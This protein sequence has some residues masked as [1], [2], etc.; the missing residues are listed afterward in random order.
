MASE[1]ALGP[2]L[3]HILEEL[4][5][6]I[7]FTGAAIG[8]LE[9]DEVVILD[10]TGPAPCDRVIGARICLEQDSGYRRVIEKQAPIVVADIWEDVGLPGSAWPI[11]DEMLSE[12]MGYARSWL[13]AP[14]VAKGK[15]IGV[16]RLDHVEPGRFTEAEGQQVLALAYQVAV[17]IV[18]AQLHEEAQRTAAM[19]ERERIARELHDSVSQALYGIV[20]GVHATRQRLGPEQEWIQARLDYLLSLAET[21]LAEMRALIFELRPDMKAVGG[22]VGALERHADM[23]RARYGLNVETDFPAEPELPSP[24]KEALYRIAQEGTNNIGKHADAR[25]VRMRLQQP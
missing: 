11:W 8:L 9:K 20:L 10:Y 13:G 19:A 4:K 15:T 14:L 25:N 23:L 12:A 2:L 24:V 22:L 18:N 1:L 17:A 7:D 16:L 6:A 21:G 3:A 5:T